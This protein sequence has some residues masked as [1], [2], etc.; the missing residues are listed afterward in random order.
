M[1]NLPLRTLTLLLLIVVGC[2]PAATT[3]T[4]ATQAIP[5]ESAVVTAEDFDVTVQAV[6]TLKADQ[7][8][9]LKPK[10]AGRIRE[11]HLVEGSP[12]EAGTILIRL[13]DDALRAQLDL[14]RASLTAAQVLARNAR[15]QYDR[16]DA[17]LRKDVASQQQY[18]DARA[19]LD[20]TT[21]ALGVAEANVAFADAQLAD[22]IVRAPFPGVLGQRRVDLGAFV[23]EGEALAA[24]VDSDPVELVFAVPERH[25]GQIRLEQSVDITVVSYG[26]R[27]FPG[28]VTFIDPLVD[29]VNRTV[30]VKAVIQNP[31]LILRPGQFAT[32]TLHLDR[33][34]NM[35]SIPEEAVVPEGDRTLVFVVADGSAAA[36]PIRT[37]VRLPGR[38]EVIE[39]L[40]AGECVVR[41]GHEK[42]KTDVALPVQDTTT[43][44]EG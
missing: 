38:V 2:R 10:R 39:G 17:L 34:S 6:G 11:L 16:I 28:T 41:T 15:Q 29:P 42:L 13:D 18:D 12:V 35:P 25:L 31:D 26:D 43:A 5:I 3:P 24:L 36:R 4:A 32:A 20:R 21:A 40:R 9:D 33:H 23:K 8:V 22:M 7:L 14:A 30:A 19:E 37:G 27:V 1:L 44:A